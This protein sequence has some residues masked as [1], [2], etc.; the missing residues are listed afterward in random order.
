MKVLL[1]LVAILFVLAAPGPRAGFL[2]PDP[3]SGAGSPG[4]VRALLL[5]CSYYGANYNLI[6]DVME[7]YGWDI[8]TVG[9]TATVAPCYYGGPITVD[10]LVSE[11]ADLS[12]YDFL[13][14]MPSRKS[15]PGG[16]HS[17]LLG[18]PEALSL[19][20]QAASDSLLIV[21]FCGGTRVLAAADVINGVTVTGA[22]EYAQE[23]IDAGAIWAGDT[24][25]PVLDGRFF[26][27]TRN[28]INSRRICELIR[29]YMIEERAGSK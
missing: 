25:H 14:I 8:T 9:V 13:A 28:Q 16:A 4:E 21:A 19:V 27:S 2:E 1:S 11:I 15:Q 26:T 20:A 12:Q 24:G 18:S 22:A 17:Q 10:T 7:L 3:A 5:V 29:T 23:Y 6:R